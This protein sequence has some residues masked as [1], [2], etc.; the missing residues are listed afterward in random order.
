MPELCCAGQCWTV[1]AGANLLDALNLAGYRV[2][3]SCRA[4]SCHACL[5][6]CTEGEP[7]D[8]R[9]DALPPEQRAAGWRLA[10]QCRVRE[11][12]T[13]RVYDPEREGIPASVHSLDW[14]AS[15]LARLRLQPRRPFRY[16]AGQHVLLW[17]T[18][19]VARPY[20]LASLPV[21]DAWLEFH[22]DCRKPGLFADRMRRLAPGDTLRLGNLHG[23]ALHYDP[24]WD[25]QPLLLLASGT[26][27]APLWAI[28]REAL[29]QGHG[30]PI[31]LVHLG[32]G[33]M[34]EALQALARQHPQVDLE[35]IEE[36][37]GR[38]WLAALQPASRRTIALLCG[39]DDF[40]QAATRR[41]FMAGLPRG[42]IFS[43]TF[44]SATH[45]A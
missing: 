20:S 27:L 7:E 30:A 18:Q 33:Y 37:Q 36:G 16:D 14:P 43:D 39:G 35:R 4:G 15:G 19:D 17:A 1:E 24:L 12:L 23:G 13:V 44:V 38:Q 9:P 2:P 28:L 8:A 10:C 3:Y 42:Q 32:S 41:L 34:D 25:G 21:E 40:V 31:R 6:L 26:G 29:R 45:D 11:R 22:I 5:V